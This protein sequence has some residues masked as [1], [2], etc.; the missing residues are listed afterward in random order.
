[1]LAPLKRF[2]ARQSGAVAAEFVILFP[3]YMTILLCAIESAIYMTRYA[4]LDRGVDIAIRELRLGTED[5]PE[6]E[7]FKQ[8][9]CDNAQYVPDCINVI[10]VELTRVDMNTW[11]GLDG[12]ARCR[13]L[14]SDIDPFD[15]TEYT[16]GTNNELMM[17]RV[18]A[19]YR[20]MMPSTQFGMGL[21]T[22]GDRY[23]LVIT[24]AFVNEPS[25]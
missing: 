1:M 5:P 9:I 8:L 23:A 10:Q 11:V 16:V 6:F 3:L 22:V 13:D 21:Q 2:V 4:M 19:L 15:Q 24:S 25:T 18:C 20:P 17:V 14:A 12:P 7:E